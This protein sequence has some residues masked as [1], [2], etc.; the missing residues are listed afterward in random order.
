MN[1]VRILESRKDWKRCQILLGKYTVSSFLLCISMAAWHET[2]ISL[3]KNAIE[4]FM[5][6]SFS[7]FYEELF[8][9]GWQVYCHD[10]SLSLPYMQHSSNYKRRKFGERIHVSSN[11]ES[12][13][14][15][16]HIDKEYMDTISIPVLSNFNEHCS[17][18]RTPF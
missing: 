7:R 15:I 11:E 10:F 8:G 4:L 1:A 18:T 6:C 5:Y 13:L 3:L 14:P 9:F 17:A 12:I 2:V 16:I